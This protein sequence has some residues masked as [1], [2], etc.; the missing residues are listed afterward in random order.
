MHKLSIVYLKY[1]THKKACLLSK[2]LSKYSNHCII[3]MIIHIQ[4]SSKHSAQ[5]VMDS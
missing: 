2:A 4:T 5:N 3:V 1:N